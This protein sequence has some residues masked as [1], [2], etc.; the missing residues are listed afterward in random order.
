MPFT[1]T[2]VHDTKVAVSF[3]HLWDKTGF[4]LSSQFPR[5]F[6]RAS[7]TLR[8]LLQLAILF[9]QLSIYLSV[10]ILFNT[11]ALVLPIPASGRLNLA[12]VLLDLPA[13]IVDLF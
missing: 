4:V 9:V 7:F 2:Q 3:K 10:L 1:D 6:F 12:I 5:S 13:A 8:L 11:R